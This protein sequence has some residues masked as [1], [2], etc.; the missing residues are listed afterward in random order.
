MLHHEESP[1][2]SQYENL[3]I[4][5]RAY[6]LMT[7][8]KTRSLNNVGIWIKKYIYKIV[9]RYLFKTDILVYNFHRPSSK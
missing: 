7:K 6:N 8:S 2:K 3:K 4:L 1:E 9:L 5:F